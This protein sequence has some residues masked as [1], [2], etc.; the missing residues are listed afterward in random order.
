MSICGQLAMSIDR[1][2]GAAAQITRLGLVTA[3]I[4]LSPSNASAQRIVSDPSVASKHPLPDFS[5]A[6]YGF[7]VGEIPQS[8]GTTIDVTDFGV[9]PDD[10]L[11][12]SDAMQRAF[13]AA[14][15]IDGKVVVLLPK[16]R[17]QLTEVLRIDRGDFV[18]RGA[19]SSAGGTEIWLPRPLDLV[20][21]SSQ[22]DELR[23]YLV[24]ENKREVQPENNID[25]LFSEWSWSGGFLFVGPPGTRPVSYD[26]SKDVRDPVIAH[27]VS[28]QQFSREVKVDNASELRIGMV[29]QL[30][31][32]PV[33]GEDSAIIDSIYGPTELPIGSHHWTFPNRP[34]VAQATRIVAIN[35]S[36]ITLG[37]PLLHDVRRD[38]PATVARWE[39]LQNV[40]IEAMA[41]RFPASASFGHHL[42]PGY[43]AIYLTGLFDGWARDLVVDNADSALMTDNAA[44]LTIENVTT[45][46]EREAHYAVHVGAAHNILVRHLRIENSVIHPLSVNT[47]S[48]RSVFTDATVLRDGILDQH[49]GSNHQNLFD[50]VTMH[51]V[52][53]Y[54]DKTWTYRL[55]EGGGA[56]YW[57]PGHGLYNTTWNVRLI[58]PSEFSRKEKVTVTSGTEGPGAHIVG[59]WTDTNQLSFEYRPDPYSENIGEVP[60][61]KSLYHYQLERRSTSVN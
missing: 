44:S 41:F 5:Y 57:K 47:R 40:G 25:Y 35:G 10:N 28:G 26:G 21:Q 14:R 27:A 45:T 51:I 32:F 15:K 2:L 59:L 17:I 16:G 36:V 33:D 9:V 23:T 11:D 48:T 1:Q 20:D 3:L 58:L 18:L 24:K 38:Q 22:W 6:G 29:I 34:T 12:D 54:V 42:E 61:I 52:P 8:G 19:G 46:G 37:D 43:N 53:R 31:W 30:Q 4:M 50:N 39:H 56:G 13:A 60:E 49:S 55:W 7:G